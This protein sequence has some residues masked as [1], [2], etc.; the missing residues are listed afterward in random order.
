[1]ELGFKKLDVWNKAIDFADSV[2]DLTE[3]LNTQS[4]HYRLIEQV[5]ACSAS[6]SANIAEGK[7]R[8]SNKEF[9]QFLYI[10]RASLYETIS[11]LSLFEK[12]KWITK[13]QLN[14]LEEEAIELASMIKGLINAIAKNLK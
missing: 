13:D 1:M 12:R 5:E 11:F 7:G 10:A 4:K 14:E 6:V 9:I 2:I 3:K 8:N